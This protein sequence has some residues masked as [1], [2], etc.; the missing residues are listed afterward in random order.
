[1]VSIDVQE[2]VHKHRCSQDLQ[3][4]V[5]LSKITD[6]HGQFK[7]NSGERNFT[8]NFKDFFLKGGRSHPPTPPAYA[9]DKHCVTKTVP[10]TSLNPLNPN[11]RFSGTNQE[12]Q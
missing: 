4:G 7:K 9:Y 12:W 2:S 6:F 5:V 10:D 3:R 8:V 11:S 1:M